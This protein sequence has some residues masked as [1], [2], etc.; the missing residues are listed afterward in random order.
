MRIKPGVPAW[1]VILMR[2]RA[3]DAAIL[4]SMAAA[5]HARHAAA[6][7]ARPLCPHGYA[8][9]PSP[10]SGNTPICPQCNPVDVDT[11]PF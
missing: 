9:D 7:N 4:T 1:L 3:R 8:T 10:F 11:V 6:P 5:E 2:K